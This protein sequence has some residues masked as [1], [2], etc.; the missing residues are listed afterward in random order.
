MN[1]TLQDLVFI[2][3]IAHFA[4]SAGSLLVPK[5]LSW[6]MELRSLRPL[7]RQMFWTYA[8][9]ILVT[10]ICFGIVS[11]AGAQELLDHSFL[12]KSI[13]LFIAMYWF[14]RLVIQFFYFDRSDAPKG[15]QYT[16]GE[17]AL[18]GMFFMFTLAYSIAFAHNMQWL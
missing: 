14:A 13:T 6:G 11:V 7:Y 15:L 8:G 9:Y 16:I 18:V 10:N 3:G 17:A 4:L 5:A 12:A 2:A 1:L